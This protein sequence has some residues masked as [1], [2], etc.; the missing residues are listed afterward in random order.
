MGVDRADDPEYFPTRGF[1]VRGADDQPIV[2]PTRKAEALLAV[3][4]ATPGAAHRRERL[5]TLLWPNNSDEQARSSL[6]QTLALLRKALAPAGLPGI[7]A[8]GDT[9][10]MDPAG[11]EVDTAA[12]DAAVAAGT[13]EALGEAIALY[14]GDFL[15]GMALP[16]GEA[17][18]EWLGLERAQRRNGVIK[19]CEQLLAHHVDKGD[20]AAGLAVGERLLLLEPTSE[21]ACRGL[22]TL[23]HRQGARAAAAREYERCRQIL[24]SEL[25]VEPAPETTA[26]L[27]EILAPVTTVAAADDGMPSIA[28]LPL[29]SPPGDADQAYVADGFAEDVIRELSRFRSLNVI[30]RHSAFA[31]RGLKLSP[32]EIGDRLGAR[33]LLSGT[34]RRTGPSSRLGVDLV[35]AA[36][37]RQLWGGRFD[38][39]L[40]RNFEVQDE[41]ARAVASTLA[42]RIDEAMLKQARRKPLESLQAYDCW[43]RGLD[44]VHHDSPEKQEEARAC[45]HRA[46]ELDPS[47]ARAYSGLSLAH[48]NEWNCHNWNRWAERETCAFESARRAVEIDDSDHVTHFIL[49]RIYLYRRD[50]APAEQHLVRAE[51]LNPNDADMLVQLALAWAYL[52]EA[53][54]A[55]RL[56]ELALRLNPLH[57]TWYFMFMLPAAMIQQRYRDVIAMGLRCLDEATDTPAYVAAAYAHLGEMEEARRVLDIH[58]GYFRRRIT[59]GRPPR[60]GEAHDW[61]KLVNPYRQQAHLDLLIEGVTKAGLSVPVPIRDVAASKP[62]LVSSRGT[63]S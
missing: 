21:V 7:A 51:A 2:F 31:L 14:R 57:D 60:P 35:D 52:G 62:T 37:G 18:E 11:V 48:F 4:A 58:L 16:G 28:V 3:L 26:L 41:I 43:L 15:D 8:H 23:H 38:F 33:Y 9:L 42:L 54:R 39:T 17:F 20:I 56:A 46:L 55:Q 45:F 27:R 32:R 6:R 59:Y 5:A 29:E 19:A 47:Y 53:D 12:F 1:A 10:V 30:A 49:G 22:M 61:L 50:F 44:C 25:G 40:D 24:A 63:T 13:P 34:L 36:S